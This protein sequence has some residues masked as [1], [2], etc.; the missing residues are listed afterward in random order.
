MNKISKN[1]KGFSAMEGLLAVLIIAV[2]GFG[3]YYVWHT[4]HNKK[5][6]AVTTNTSNK[7]TP[8][9]PNPYAGWKSFCATA[10]GLCLQYPS[11][12]T[13]KQDTQYYEVDTITSPSN[14]VD[15]QYLPTGGPGGCTGNPDTIHVLDVLQMSTKTLEVINLAKETTNNPSAGFRVADY[16]VDLGATAADTA[17]TPFTKGAVITSSYEPSCYSSKQGKLQVEP[18]YTD[19][20]RQSLTFN[21]YPTL[22]DAQAWFNTQDVKTGNLILQSAKLK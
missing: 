21:P 8:T 11:S 6:T 12:W 5:I 18:V 7:A 17:L 19:A 2:I 10:T 4:Q 9:A 14:Q 15:V 1:E 3:G 13:L 16:V 20:Q 22:A